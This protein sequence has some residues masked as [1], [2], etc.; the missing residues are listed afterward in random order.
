[1][2]Y[3]TVEDVAEMLHMGPD[4]VRR[5]AAEG[6][7]PARKAGRRWLFHPE[8][9]DKYMRNEWHSTSEK[10]GELGGSDSLLAARLFAEAAVLENVS[11]PRNTK[12]RSGR[13]TSGNKN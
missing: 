5:K 7:L 9:L 8:L 13:G 10:P 11:S 3:Y 1:M 4:A 6:S 2:T 12:P